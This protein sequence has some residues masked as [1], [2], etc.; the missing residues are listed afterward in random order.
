VRSVTSTSFSFDSVYVAAVGQTD[1][2]SVR[3]QFAEVKTTS[4]R[5]PMGDSRGRC[6]FLRVQKGVTR[7]LGGIDQR[8]ENVNREPFF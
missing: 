3:R 8:A 1:A 4:A 6:P 5:K 2:S 7:R